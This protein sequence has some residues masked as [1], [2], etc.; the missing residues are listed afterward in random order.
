[1]PPLM[2]KNLYDIAE[3]VLAIAMEGLR[4]RAQKNNDG[5]DERIF[6]KPLENIIASRTTVTD[7]IRQFYQSDPENKHALYKEF[8]F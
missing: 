8:S 3:D 2:V 7:K 4:D 5:N 6:L 1:M